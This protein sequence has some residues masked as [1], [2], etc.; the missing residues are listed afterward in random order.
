MNNPVYKKKRFIRL[1]LEHIPN[2][3]EQTPE[4]ANN[5]ST[6]HLIAWR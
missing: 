1:G 5:Y 4:E 2:A 3:I 6:C